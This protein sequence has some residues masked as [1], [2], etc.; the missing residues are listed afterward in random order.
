MWQR[1]LLVIDVLS[2]PLP[3]HTTGPHPLATF[4]ARSTCVTLLSPKEAGWEGCEPC[5]PG[6]QKIFRSACSRALV[7]ETMGTMG[8]IRAGPLGKVEQQDRKSLGP[9]VAAAGGPACWRRL[10]CAE[11]RGGKKLRLCLS[12]C[13]PCAMGLVRQLSSP[14]LVQVEATIISHRIIPILEVGEPRQGVVGVE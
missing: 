8:T 10:P 3:R 5:Q 4:A 13:P 6:L 2:H 14:W 1:L 12:Q 9:S 7:V 11:T